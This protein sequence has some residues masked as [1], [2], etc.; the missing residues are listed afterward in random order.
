[1]EG[2]K[3]IPGLE[4]ALTQ[5]FLLINTPATSFQDAAQF[6]TFALAMTNPATAIF[7]LVGGLGLARTARLFR[8][9]AATFKVPINSVATQ[10]FWS[11]APIQWG[12]YAA[13]YALAPTSP[14]PEAHSASENR[15]GNDL[16]NRLRGA[17]LVYDFMVQFYVDDVKTP[18]EDASVEWKEEDAPFINVARLV[19]PMQD[20]SSMQSEKQRSFGESLSFDPWHATADFRPLGDLMRARAV[21]YKHSVLNRGAA[22][23]PTGKETF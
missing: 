18:I 12:Q 21:A 11:A 23:E 15:L 9:L 3:I 5:D 7:K 8:N 6:M 13:H 19:I 14:S 20:L 2:K 22:A 17:P 10:R 16:A 4:D 1:V